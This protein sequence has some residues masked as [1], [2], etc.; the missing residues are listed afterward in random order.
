M[1]RGLD[2]GI[3]E[4]LEILDQLPFE[5]RNMD[6]FI[7]STSDILR[8][9]S[10]LLGAA[11]QLTTEVDADTLHRTVKSCQHER[12]MLLRAIRVFFDIADFESRLQA[13]LLHKRSSLFT[14]LFS[15]KL[16][17]FSCHSEQWNGTFSEKEV[18]IQASPPPVHIHS[19]LKASA[20][21]AT[22]CS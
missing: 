2:R 5:L 20:R 9:K 6:S 21:R 16:R 18:Q 11:G 15:Q 8:A 1:V 19:A 7:S 14:L 10:A 12:D 22:T 13:K 4:F 17:L 3:E